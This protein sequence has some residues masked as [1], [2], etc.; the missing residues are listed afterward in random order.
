MP[1]DQTSGQRRFTVIE[2]PVLPMVRESLLLPFKCLPELVKFGKMPFMLILAID[3]LCYGLE[4][5]DI[6]RSLTGILMLIAHFILFTPF[7][8][9]WTKLAIRGRQAVAKHPAFAYSRTQL[10]YL[11]ATMVMIVA[12]TICGGFPFA[13]LRYAQRIFDN[14]LVL[15]AGGGFFLGLCVYLIGYLRLGFVFPAIAI[16][17]YAGI[18]AAWKQTAGNIERLAAIVVLSYLPYWLIRQ[19]FEWYT[20][21]HPPGVV[22][23]AR[24]IVDQLLIAMATT[25]LAGTALAYKTLVLDQPQDEVATPSISAAR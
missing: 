20:G 13:L 5:Q 19:A 23:A 17:R 6:S 15:L 16:G 24:G 21:Y 2:L 10:I 9:A 4:R 22:A 7:A 3:V 1:N 18:A 8:V 14:Q 11:L 25:A 12:L